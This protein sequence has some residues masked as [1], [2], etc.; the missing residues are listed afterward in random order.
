MAA[1]D[2]LVDF[3]EL[4]PENYLGVGGER[5]RRLQAVSSRWPVLTHGLA[6]S[7]GGP[8]PLDGAY[9]EGIADFV[10]EMGSPW[11]SDHLCSGRAHGRHS[12]E[13]LPLEMTAH[14]AA[15]VS[16]RIRQAAAV[17]SVPM[18]V[19]NVSAYG[20]WPSDTLE[21]A[22]FITEVIERAGCGLLLDVNNVLVN[23]INFQLDPLETLARLPLE[24]TVAIHVAGFDRRA[25]D[26]VID[27]H[28][29]P[30][31]DRVWPLLE[32][33]LARTGPVPVL[34]ERDN[35][36]PPLDEL[37]GELETIRAVGARVFGERP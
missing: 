26:L 37:V 3:V 28:G 29:A 10:S 5:R 19:E 20:R 22:D 16:D 30:V 15:D 13:L 1:P 21:E 32:A 9:L 6:M 7:L 27:T 34:L 33:A 12:H 24:A 18:A 8:D 14:K 11:H 36:I 31:D 17:L 23:A 25:P 35:D 2:G 4:A